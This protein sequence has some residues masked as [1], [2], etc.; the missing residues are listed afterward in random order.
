MV[1]RVQ[2]NNILPKRLAGGIVNSA[3]FPVHDGERRHVFGAGFSRNRRADMIRRND[4]SLGIDPAG[5]IRP[6][7]VRPVGPDDQAER[8]L[9][10]ARLQPLDCLGNRDILVIPVMAGEVET[11]F[12]RLRVMADFPK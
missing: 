2:K 3:E 6:R 4:Q 11:V 9:G 8:F 1:A 5:F 10:A 7:N 12:R